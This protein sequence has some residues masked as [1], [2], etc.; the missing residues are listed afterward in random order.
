MIPLINV[1]LRLLFWASDLHNQWTQLPMY[2]LPPDISKTSWTPHIQYC[3]HDLSPQNL[4]FQSCYLTVILTTVHPHTQARKNLGIILDTPFSINSHTHFII[5]SYHFIF[6]ISNLSTSFHL[7]Y[8]HPNSLSWS[9]ANTRNW[10]L[11]SPLALLQSN[12]PHCSQRDLFE[13]PISSCCPCL[14]NFKSF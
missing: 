12:S 14:K 7:H 3:I 4:I 9:T 1:Q 13:G 11:V 8:Y 10:L 5:K 6:Q 2:H